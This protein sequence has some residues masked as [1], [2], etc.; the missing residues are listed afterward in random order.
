MSQFNTTI[1]LLFF[2]F[3]LS[4]Q[5]VNSTAVEQKIVEIET[6]L[7][8]RNFDSAITKID[9]LFLSYKSPYLWRL[10][11]EAITKFNNRFV[12]D[13]IMFKAALACF[14][15]AL[16]MDPEY[17]QGVHARAFLYFTH[18]FYPEAIN[19]LSYALKLCEKDE[20]TI[21]I[22]NLRG[23][24]FLHMRKYE[25][26]LDDFR[27]VLKIDAMYD[28][29]LSSAALTFSNLGESEKAI[30]LIKRAIV[31]EPEDIRYQVNLGFVYLQAEQFQKAEQIFNDLL[32]KM[33]QRDPVVLNNR[34]FV[35]LKLGEIEL[36]LKDFEESIELY[37]DNSFAFKNLALLYIETNQLEQACEAL[38]QALQLK[39][40]ETYG[41][42]VHLLQA[43]Y[44]EN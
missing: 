32:E 19:D 15:E 34:G 35:R 17:F 3:V 14:N 12:V 22:L 37:P 33:D 40:A 13:S 25:E 21:L 44:C 6:E 18:Q 23:I 10:K 4:G 5:N 42:E 9:S 38:D 8:N 1:L 28:Q 27:K 26:A 2:S 7:E 41:D 11:G 16:K 36:A 43:E 29:T 24:I 30:K 20:E 39:F 31:L